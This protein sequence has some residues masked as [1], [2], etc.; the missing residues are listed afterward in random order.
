[1]YHSFSPFAFVNNFKD[2][3]EYY[4]TMCIF[5]GNFSGQS[6][7]FNLKYKTIL[8]HYLKK[9]CILDSNGLIN[10]KLCTAMEKWL[11]SVKTVNSLIFANFG[12]FGMFKGKK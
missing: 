7:S 11:I 12:R 4:K 8:L 3:S 1:M 2:F 5:L 9:S 6:V 10:L